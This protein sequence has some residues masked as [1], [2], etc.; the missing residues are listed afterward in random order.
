MSDEIKLLPCAGWPSPCPYSGTEETIFGELPL[1][2]KCFKV[3]GDDFQD[4]LDN[5]VGATDD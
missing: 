4:A 3:A 2:L 5:V 1:C